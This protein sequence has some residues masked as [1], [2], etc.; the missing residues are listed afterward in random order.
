MNL[1]KI[2]LFICIATVTLVSCKK[3]EDLKAKEEKLMKEQLGST[4]VDFYKAM[5]IT[6]R[7]T[8]AMPDDPKFA[9]ARK[10]MLGL[11]TGIFRYSVAKDGTINTDT[12]SISVMELVAMGKSFYSAKDVLLNTDEDSLPTILD[13]I[14]YLLGSKEI[15]STK[16]L[17]YFGSY[18]GNFEHAILG[19]IWFVTPSAPKE[20]CLYELHKTDE[21]KIAD[22]EI[23]VTTKLAKSFIYLDNEYYWHS[24]ERS[25]QYLQTVEDNKEYF[26]KNPM[27]NL[28][29]EVKIATP[30]QQYY[31]LHSL[32][33]VMRALAEEKMDMQDEA[34]ED[35]GLFVEE[36]EKGGG[37][38][39]LV[40]MCGAYINIKKENKDKALVYL[41]KLEKS[42][43]IGEPERKAVT[44]I[45]SYM[46]DRDSKKAL[47][48]FKDKMAILTI[49]FDLMKSRLAEI[50][51]M[52]QFKTSKEGE[53]FYGFQK[54]VNDQSELINSLESSTNVDS[55]SSKA[56]N[57][58]KDF[59]GPDDKKD[60]KEKK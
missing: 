42:D 49:T 56:K 58:V 8:A 10:N 19:A 21:D 57:L 37:D 48:K 13:N 41:G 59:F 36:A 34:D 7:S 51:Q 43:K 40:W 27:L 32:G 3:E 12:T 11:V 6:V 35:L 53:K 22:K 46:N 55:L 44:E 52:Q 14:L 15:Q 54:S 38:N 60:D 33:Y 50:K 20:F 28:F 29:E 4:K 39:E 16:N 24:K 26:L 5:K 17:T 30:E 47:T 2:I 1:S 25:D 18:N 31:Q 9:E 45:K 23:M